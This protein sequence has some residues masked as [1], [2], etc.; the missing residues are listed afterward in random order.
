MMG[1]V[2]YFVVFATLTSAC[3][4]TRNQEPSKA[5]TSI[6]GIWRVTNMEVDGFHIPLE[7]AEEKIDYEIRNGLFARVGPE[8]VRFN[9]EIVSQDSKSWL[10]M[11][12]FR[13]PTS[14]ALFKCDG[15]T[16]VM[17][18]DSQGMQKANEFKT[19]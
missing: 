2:V 9:Y 10:R 5:G 19:W 13:Q 15:N 4:S 18:W 8:T 7:F 17:C 12:G 11:T 16:L 1:K 14:Y 3:S 6:E